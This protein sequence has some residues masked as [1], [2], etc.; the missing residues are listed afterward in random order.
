MQFTIKGGVYFYQ[1]FK[2]DFLPLFGSDFIDQ[3]HFAFYRPQC[4]NMSTDPSEKSN[5]L[6]AGVH[7]RNVLKQTKRVNVCFVPE[8][9]MITAKHYK[10]H[11]LLHCSLVILSRLQRC[12][13]CSPRHFAVLSKKVAKLQ[14]FVR[15]LV[16]ESDMDKI[17]LKI[18][19][20]LVLFMVLPQQDYR[21]ALCLVPKHGLESAGFPYAFLTAFH[22]AYTHTRCSY[23]LQTTDPHYYLGIFIETNLNFVKKAWRCFDHWWARLRRLAEAISTCSQKM[24]E[25]NAYMSVVKMLV[26]CYR[27]QTMQ[28]KWVTCLSDH[29]TVKNV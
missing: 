12:W 3:H 7:D 20:H 14:V 22:V 21:Y 17:N 27:N 19:A 11:S 16:F 25:C 9:I 10:K 29:L 28:V 26:R 2:S 6:P 4:E 15:Q 13:R 18:V 23:W 1:Q 8:N 5:F 24:F